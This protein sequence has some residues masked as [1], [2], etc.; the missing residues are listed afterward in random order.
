[1]EFRANE[2]QV[3]IREEGRNTQP[4]GDA[5]APTLV[6]IRGQR[7]TGRDRRRDRIL[8]LKET[9]NLLCCLGFRANEEQVGIRKEGQ[10]T[11]PQG[12]TEARA[13]LGIKG[14]GGT[15]RDQEGRTGCS[16]SRRRRSSCAAWDSVP[17]RSR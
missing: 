2:E 16:A 9:Q 13:L 8:S 6:G 1:L 5:E 15:G 7:G 12:D 4:Q 14:L 17:R 3:G 11:Q 10:D